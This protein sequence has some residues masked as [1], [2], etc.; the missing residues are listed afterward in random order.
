[1]LPR[2]VFSKIDNSKCVLG[3]ALKWKKQRIPQGGKNTC[4]ILMNHHEY[5]CYIAEDRPDT[6]YLNSH[7]RSHICGACTFNSEIWKDL[8]IELMGQDSVADLDIISV[9][10][11]GD[12][13]GCCSS[14]FSLWLQR[15]PEASWKTNWF[16]CP[17]QDKVK[18][19]SIGNYEIINI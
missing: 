19:T 9:N 7:V 18:C 14:L 12:V 16:D 17:D 2:C 10:H 5:F 6:R 1:M 13:I 4:T 15:Q 8:G 11:R 3:E